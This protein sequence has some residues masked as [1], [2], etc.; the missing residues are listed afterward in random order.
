MDLPIPMLEY[1]E[2]DFIEFVPG[3]TSERFQILHGVTNE[4]GTN[5]KSFAAVLIWEKLAFGDDADAW[6]LVHEFHYNWDSSIEGWISLSAWI[7][8]DLKKLVTCLQMKDKGFKDKLRIYELDTDSLVSTIATP[9]GVRSFS[10]CPDGHHIIFVDSMNRAREHSIATGQLIRQFLGVNIIANSSFL[11]RHLPICFIDGHVEL[12]H[13]DRRV[14]VLGVQ[15]GLD[16]AGYVSIHLTN[17]KMR[18]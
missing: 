4:D 9:A 18:Q 14:Q 16:D 15:Q 1:D 10:F 13:H 11:S 7:S 2:T 6:R 8:P 17:S 5:D 3:A 12:L